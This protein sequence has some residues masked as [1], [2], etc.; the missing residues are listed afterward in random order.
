MARIFDLSECTTESD[1]VAA[2]E[3]YGLGSRV[4]F[5]DDDYGWVR[6]AVSGNY[7]YICKI[8]AAV[9]RQNTAKYFYLP[10]CDMAKGKLESTLLI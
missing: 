4:S 10:W 6:G 1:I 7:P 3:R 8:T 5:W 9:G 2:K